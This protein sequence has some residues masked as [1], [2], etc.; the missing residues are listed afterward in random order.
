MT[1]KNFGLDGFVLKSIAMVAMLIDHMGAVLFPQYLGMRMIG[2]IAFPIYCFLLVE[3]AM[4]TSDIRKYELRLFLFALVSELPF[5]LAFQGTIDFNHQN[6]FF[7]LLLGVIGIDLAQRW[8]SKLN[9]IL[10]FIILVIVAEFLRTDYGGSGIVFIFFYYLLY[11]KKVI[12]QLAFVLENYLLYGSGVQI[13]AS[14]AV[15]PML[16]YNG[17]KGPSLKY[18]FYVFYP[19][20]LLILYL[21][22]RVMWYQ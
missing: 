18:V 1:E 21:I 10:I 7:T 5:D 8:K 2:R 12:K 14:F 17:K 20:H 13:Y 11:Q 9:T 3:G 4:H 22:S 6:V 16:L 15:L 19:A